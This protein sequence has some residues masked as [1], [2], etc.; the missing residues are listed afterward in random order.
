VWERLWDVGGEEKD[1]GVA[2]AEGNAGGV[3][4]L[5]SRWLRVNCDHCRRG[6]GWQMFGGL[7]NF[8][9]NCILELVHAQFWKHSFSFMHV[10]DKRSS[11]ELHP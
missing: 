6:I 5:R 3:G 8:F 9:L 2:G 11:T 4:F 1:E 10:P 7:S